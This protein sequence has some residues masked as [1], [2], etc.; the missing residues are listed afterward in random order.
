MWV[1]WANKKQREQQ[2]IAASHRL[3]GDRN[4][5]VRQAD[6]LFQTAKRISASSHIQ[7]SL[8]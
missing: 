4:S 8:V 2:L 1:W 3:P 6:A 7:L 5:S